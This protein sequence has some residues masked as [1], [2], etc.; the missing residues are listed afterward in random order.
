MSNRRMLEAIAAELRRHGVPKGEAAR[1]LEELEDH[2]ADLVAEQG[3]SMNESVEIDDRI[4]SRLGQPDVL[5][6]AALAVSWA[7]MG[8]R[9][10]PASSRESATVPTAPYRSTAIGAW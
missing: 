1:L 7:F 6:A 9:S 3:G 10:A 2:V 8:S 5:V 4:A